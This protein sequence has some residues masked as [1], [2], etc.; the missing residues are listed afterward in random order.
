MATDHGPAAPSG[1]HALLA[2]FSGPEALL[3]GAQRTRAAGYR[4]V[5]AYSPLPVHGLAEALGHRPSRLPFL[6]LAGGIL[7]G[8]GGYSLCYYISVIAYPLNV[9]GRPLHSGLSFIPVTFELTILVAALGA[10]FGMILA[11]GLPRL[12]H[13]VFNVSRFARASQDRFFLCIEARDPL[14]H[15]EE[16]RRFLQ[17]L[18]PDEVSDVEP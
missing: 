7:G 10:V 16:T 15:R 11:N 2:E 6:V 13:P 18:G 17:A 9:G 1:L 4:A 12:Y 8:L 14:F 5:E 3:E